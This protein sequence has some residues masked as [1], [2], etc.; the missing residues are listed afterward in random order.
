VRPAEFTVALKIEGP[1]EGMYEKHGARA[2]SNHGGCAI[3]ADAKRVR[4][5]VGEDWHEA[6]L[7]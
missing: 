1:A 5:Y 6:K 2:R 7:N 4:L 3:E